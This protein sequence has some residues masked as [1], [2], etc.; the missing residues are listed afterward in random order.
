MSG[1]GGAAALVFPGPGAGGGQALLGARPSPAPPRRRVRQ[2][3]HGEQQPR[4]AD[5]D[6]QQQQERQR[7]EQQEE[8]EDRAGDPAR[9]AAHHLP[10]LAGPLP[11]RLHHANDSNRR[12]AGMLRSRRG[13]VPA[14]SQEPHVSGTRLSRRGRASRRPRT[15]RP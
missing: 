14:P 10:G 6:Q 9:L 11:A 8:R 5:R 12:H 7:E 3:E 13:R 15:R 1:G 4:R 2:R